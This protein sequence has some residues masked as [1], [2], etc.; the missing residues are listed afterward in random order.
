MLS[1]NGI[2][3]VF[4]EKFFLLSPSLETWEPPPPENILAA[5]ISGATELFSAKTFAACPGG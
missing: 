3:R 2:K 5:L 4:K 1:K